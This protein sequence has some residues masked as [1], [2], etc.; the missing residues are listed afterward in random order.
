MEEL[1]FKNGDVGLH[2]FAAG[3]DS[4]PVVMLLHGFPE[5]W[6]GWT[7]LFG[8]YPLGNWSLL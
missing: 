2:A 6:Y 1:S 4:G 5:F 7:S 8:V 3:P